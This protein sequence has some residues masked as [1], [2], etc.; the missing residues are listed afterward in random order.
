LQQK[1]EES[2]AFDATRRSLVALSQQI[3]QTTRRS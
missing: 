1:P 3:D 2:T